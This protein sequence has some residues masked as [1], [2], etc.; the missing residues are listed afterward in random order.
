MQRIQHFFRIFLSYSRVTKG[1]N[2]KIFIIR[3]VARALVILLF[4]LTAH[5][6]GPEYPPTNNLLSHCYGVMSGGYG[7]FNNVLY[8]DG[9]TGVLHLAIGVQGDQVV[10][11]ELGIQTGNRMRINTNNVIKAIGDAPVYLTI[12]PPLD[13][14]L[15]ITSHL[16]LLPVFIQ[17]KGGAVLLQGMID[18]VTIKNQTQFRP[19]AQLGFGVDVTPLISLIAYYQC[20]FGNNP[21]LTH[22]NVSA[23]TA[24][25][26]NLPTFQ[27]GFIGM[28]MRF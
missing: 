10:G 13:L 20:L 7:V 12:K 22:P 11:L 26:P 6:G 3:R 15:T 5:A 24:N 28:Q 14:L 4:S 27:A 1:E 8:N 21:A 2:M 16:G 18:S 23:G 17:A 9:Q 19:E 25:L